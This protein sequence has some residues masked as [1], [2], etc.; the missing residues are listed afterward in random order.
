MKKKPFYT[1]WW[2]IFIVVLF[3]IGVLSDPDKDKAEPKAKDVVASEKTDTADKKAEDKK[4]ADPKKEEPK[5]EEPKKEVVKEKPKTPKTVA[6]ELA[7]DKFEK[8]VSVNY[9]SENGRVYIK[10]LGKD[11]FTTN[12]ILDGMRMDMISIL[13]ELKTFKEVSNV[14][15][16]ILMP[17]V[18]A[19]GNE[20]DDT[21]VS[22]EVS[23]ETLDKINFDNF[24]LDSLEMVADHWW[25]HP[26]MTK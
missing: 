9:N 14:E 2:F 8:V 4:E 20:S 12:M 21:V 26:A 1:R 18:D 13:K 17:L 24:R 19:Y 22:V 15:F 10:A 3:I 16:N 23:R 11:N 6:S 5:K 7:A 25:V